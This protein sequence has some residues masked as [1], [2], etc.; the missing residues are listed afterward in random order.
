MERD[1]LD[2]DVNLAPSQ[3]APQGRTLRLHQYPPERGS[4]QDDQGE[5]AQ[6]NQRDDARP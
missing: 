2:I 1:M 4:E 3:R 6:E 5:D